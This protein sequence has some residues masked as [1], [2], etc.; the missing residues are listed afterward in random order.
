MLGPLLAAPEWRWGCPCCGPPSLPG[1]RL[2]RTLA[3]GSTS[4]SEGFRTMVRFT[5]VCEPDQAPASA[6]GKTRTR[7]HAAALSLSGSPSAGWGEL[8]FLGRI[9]VDEVLRQVDAKPNPLLQR[10][11]RP[12]RHGT[13]TISA[14]FNAPVVGNRR[15]LRRFTCLLDQP[16]PLRD[17]DLP[18]LATH[19]PSPTSL[20]ARPIGTSRNI[21][22]AVRRLGWRPSR[23]AMAMSGAMQVSG[24]SR[25]T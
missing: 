20:S 22:A 6:P 11:P 23:I 19:I 9:P 25:R 13:G 2:P 14:T 21:S 3:M 15:N 4:V 5:H 8:V 1:R 18:R 12:L 7:G 10:S 24:R 16:R 17:D